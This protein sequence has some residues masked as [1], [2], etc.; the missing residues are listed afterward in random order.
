M[1]FSDIKVYQQ[2]HF[3]VGLDTTTGTYYLSIPVSNGLVDYEEYYSIA[4]DWA[5]SSDL[6]LL[7]L[8]TF[9]AKC[10]AHKMDD[11]LL[12]QPGSNRGTPV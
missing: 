2:D 9:A 7:E 1:R 5:E 6:H 4:R 11:R 8:H 12:Q 10:R 3:S